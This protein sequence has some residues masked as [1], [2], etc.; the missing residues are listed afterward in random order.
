MSDGEV[1]WKKESTQGLGYAVC[2]W[3]GLCGA[4]SGPVWT[5]LLGWRG[6][7]PR[8]EGG[9]MRARTL[10]ARGAGLLRARW[11]GGVPTAQVL[12]TTFRQGC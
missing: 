2:V 10:V 9:D 8:Q 12:W 6:L 4:I 11:G 3:E 7:K 1:L 5:E